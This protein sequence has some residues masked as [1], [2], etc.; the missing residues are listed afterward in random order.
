VQ[1][2]APDSL[3]LVAAV[4][5]LMR[6]EHV[7]EFCL[8]RASFMGEKIGRKPLPLSW[9]PSGHT[10]PHLLPS[11]FTVIDRRTKSGKNTVLWRIVPLPTGL[12]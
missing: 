7:V 2:I 12:N 8:T 1:V 4:R 10:L 6:H 5:S 11:E 3:P 9:E